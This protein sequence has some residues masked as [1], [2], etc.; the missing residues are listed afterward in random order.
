MPDE[1]D[2]PLTEEDASILAAMRT[3]WETVDPMPPDLVARVQFAVDLDGVDAEA[4]RLV[5]LTELAAARS[6]E[7]ARL[8]TFQ[9]DSLTIMITVEPCV[10]GTAR[11]DGWL[12]PGACHHIE[13]HCA[14]GP[15]ATESDDVGRFS[16]DA[17]PAGAMRL[18]VHGDSCRVLTPT[19][20]I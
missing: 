6:D 17:V 5:E 15:L 11:I 13:L 7:F 9:S 8:I 19:I 14:A 12:T 3:M 4:A 10:D 18:I 2:V 20:E 1:P 16:L